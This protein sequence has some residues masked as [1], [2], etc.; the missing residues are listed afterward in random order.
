M[1]YPYWT[2]I[3]FKF[4]LHELISHELFKRLFSLSLFYILY[5]Y[6]IEANIIDIEVINILKNSEKNIPQCEYPK[7]ITTKWAFYIYNNKKYD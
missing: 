7:N 1:R 5:V 6:I 3:N 4:K 2:A